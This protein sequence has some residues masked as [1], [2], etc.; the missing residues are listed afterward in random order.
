MS[1]LT[2]HMDCSRREDRGEAGADQVA[3]G[4]A[5]DG[6]SVGATA[7]WLAKVGDQTLLDI[8]RGRMRAFCGPVSQ[9]DGMGVD[10]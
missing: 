5:R 3:S 7:E 6:L 8:A 1:C 10:Y 2:E 9:G 4:C